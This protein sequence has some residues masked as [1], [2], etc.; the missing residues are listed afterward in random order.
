MLHRNK[1]W[2]HFV[3]NQNNVV[4]LNVLNCNKND[5]Q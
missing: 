1:W 4:L 5:T 3:D 2:T